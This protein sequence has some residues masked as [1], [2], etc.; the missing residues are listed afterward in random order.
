MGHIL[1]TVA[2][3]MLVYSGSFGLELLLDR[4]AT[5]EART[6]GSDALLAGS[7]DEPEPERP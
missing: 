5:V 3:L 7:G 6:M 4:Y 2:A 1:S